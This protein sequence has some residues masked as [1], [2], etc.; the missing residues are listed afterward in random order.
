M[1]DMINLF[2]PGRLCLFGEHSDWAGLH[3]MI[4]SD[5]EPGIA[6]VTGI[7]QGIYAK[8][9]KSE[10]FVLHNNAEELK[11][12]WVDFECSMKKEELDKVASSNSFFSYVTGVAAYISENYCVGGISIEITKM[13][14][15]MK[16]G[17]SSSA[18]ICVLAA[19]AFNLL[20]HLNL[21]IVGEM[22]V[23]FRG[24]RRTSSRCGRLDQACAYG[25]RPIQMTFDGDE[26]KTERVV[27][28]DTLYYVFADLQ[29]N[30]DT[31]KILSNLNKCYPF[32]SNQLEKNVHDALGKDNHKS[33]K[34]AI[35]YM[36]RGDNKALGNLMVDTQK[37]FDEKVAPACRD[38]LTAPV[39]H[40]ILNDEIVKHYVYGGKGVGSQGDGSVQFLARDEEAQ[41]KLYNYLKV[42]GFIPYKLTISPKPRIYKA[43]IPVAGYGTR[44]FPYTKVAKK[45]FLPI[46]DKDGMVKPSILVLLEQLYDSNI[47]DIYL[48]IGKE[49][50]K[51]AYHNLFRNSTLPKNIIESNNKIK[52][53]NLKLSLIEEKIKFV[54]QEE[55]R[56]LGHAVYQCKNYCDS[57]SV[58]ML[59]GDT[60][61]RS[62]SERTCSTQIIEANDEI[63]QTMISIHEIPLAKVENYGIVTGEWLDNSQ[64]KM[65]VTRC[66]EKPSVEYAREYLSVKKNGKKC[67][68]SMFGQYILK[69]D[70]FNILAQNIKANANCQEEVGITDALNI[71]A[72]KDVLIGVVLNGEMYDIGN[73]DEYVNSIVNFRK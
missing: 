66:V 5:I 22:M 30:K 57:E 73:P 15:P 56:G 9:T 67:Y 68:F 61:Y 23:A 20:Y 37:N 51:N 8:V 44:L 71:V 7:E 40:T 28:K 32:P 10:H 39:L 41:Q 54:I 25:V 33:V 63:D 62:N 17:L 1:S 16:R 58:L 19:R 64:T 36:R 49:E 59:L 12:Q 35:D 27:V 18:T 55:R 43:I 48:I 2:V 60:I 4:N 21:N 72:Q 11:H 6:I 38:E 26:I 47:E 65:R 52:D 53:Y 45:E 70:V 34:T 69:P 31:I 13:T 24:E 50:E 29:A 46:I 42:K 14:M 3:R